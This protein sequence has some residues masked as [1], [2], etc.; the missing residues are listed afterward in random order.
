MSF[1]KKIFFLP[2]TCYG[3]KFWLWVRCTSVCL[4]TSRER[5]SEIV[6]VRRVVSIILV[7]SNSLI[8]YYHLTFASLRIS[9]SVQMSLK[10]FLFFLLSFLRAFGYHSFSPALLLMFS[11]SST[12]VILAFGG[13]LATLWKRLCPSVRHALVEKCEDTHLSCCGCA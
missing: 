2:S 8:Y 10:L 5:N 11:L 13:W 6:K 4:L 7:V 3:W 9:F 12:I 1:G